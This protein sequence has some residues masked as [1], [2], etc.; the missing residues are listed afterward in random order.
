MGSDLISI[1]VIC[2][3]VILFLMMIE[4]PLPYAL[5]SVAIIGIYLGWG[6]PALSKVGLIVYQQFFSLS[7]TPLPLFVLLACIINETEIGSDIFDASNK[8]LSRLPGG[9]VVAS[10]AAEAGMSATIGS[11][12]TTALTVGKVSVPQMEKLGY[13]RAFSI[14]AILTGGA[15][16]PLIPPSINIIVYALIARQSIG[17]L[18]IAGII[19]GILL[20]AM[21]AAY[22]IIICIIHPDI[23]PK[24]ESV[25]WKERVYSLRKVWSIIIVLIC[26]LG[27]IYLGIMTA[28]EAAGVAVVVVLILAVVFYRFRMTNLINA[29][30]ETAI[31]NGMICFMI[32][33]CMLLTYVVA[34]S[35]LAQL[36]ADYLINSG[37]SKWS[38]IIAINI[39]LIFLGCFVD[40]LTVILIT[41]PFFIPL[42]S[43]LGFDLIWFGVLMTVNSEIGI[44]TPPMGLNLFVMRQAFDLRINDL[45]KAMLPFMCVLFIFLAILITFPQIT[46]WLP[47]IMLGR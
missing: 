16:G 34:T 3:I 24:S 40:V 2:L 5:G 21:L 19:P 45:I 15:L 46:I 18:L 23:A 36:C 12:T 30:K 44:I 25:T 28:N 4:I 39:L 11:S 22:V 35:G 7:W 29:I 8:W 33:T 27:G 38:I 32:V 6:K 1:A 47:S 26:I 37:L 10:I 42:V 20:A 14:A 9:L 31:L 13:D 17:Q 43:G 41:L